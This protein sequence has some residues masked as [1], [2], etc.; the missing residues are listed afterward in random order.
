MMQKR[1]IKN[2]TFTRLVQIFIIAII[3]ISLI[4]FFAYK[5]FFKYTVENKALEIST[6]VK[7]GLT[8]HMKA[9]IMQKRGY[10]LEEIKETNNIK[11]LNIIRSQSVIDQFGASTHKSEKSYKELENSTIP[12]EAHFLWQENKSTVRAIIPYKASSK[13]KLNCLQCHNA[14]D[15]ETLGALEIEFDISKYQEL[16]SIYGYL[17]ISLLVFFALIILYFIFKFIEKYLSEPISH[18]AKEAD[19]AYKSHSDIDTNNYEISEL[20]SLAQNLNDLNHD[21]LSREKELEIKNRELKKLNSEIEATLRE[22]MVAIGEIEEVRSNDVKNHTRRVSLLSATIARDYGMSEED[23]KLIE[24]TSPLHDIGK[25]GISDD[26]LLKPDKLTKEEFEIMKTH[27][28]LGYHILNHSKRVALKTAA[29]IAYGHHEKYNGNGYPQGL[30][31]DEIPI[32]ARIVAIVDVLDALLCR[33][34][35]KEAW[36]TK[37]VLEF[38]IQERGQH[39][40]PDLV[41][42]VADNFDKYSS[43]IDS[44]V[45]KDETK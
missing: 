17:L 37:D 18:I 41:D 22:T 23:I 25:I 15:G 31:G 4:M 30:K 32:F 36:N 12:N 1:T 13:S 5:Q 39:F 34:V 38:I 8:S 40:D 11:S 14:K 42:I 2:I 27:A 3:T 19:D 16:T 44:L 20:D 24:L 33:R 9:N 35:Y 6:I 43:L 26:I 7:A 21:V 28:K 10:F 45:I 29:E